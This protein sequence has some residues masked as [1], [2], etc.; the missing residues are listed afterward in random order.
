VFDRGW[1]IMGIFKSLDRKTKLLRIPHSISWCLWGQGLALAKLGWGLELT[2]F[3]ENFANSRVYIQ[4]KH[5]Y[6]NILRSSFW[7]RDQ[8]W[9]QQMSQC[10]IQFWIVL[11]NTYNFKDW[12]IL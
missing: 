10:N 2:C 4:V 7:W 6:E 12:V 8:A 5:V 11:A 9:P 3:G 1:K